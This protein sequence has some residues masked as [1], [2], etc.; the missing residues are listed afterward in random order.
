MS[1]L[2]VPSR[3]RIYSFFLIPL[4][5]F[6]N[7]STNDLSS[8]KNRNATALLLMQTLQSTRQ[9]FSVPADT[10]DTVV[11]APNHTGLG[12]QDKAKAINGVRGAGNY[13]GSGD[14][15]SLTATGQGSSI[16][17]EWSGR[18]ITNGAGIDF[19][20][21]ENPFY[22]NSSSAKAFLEPTLVE[23]S[24]DNIKYCGFNPTYSNIP[25]TSFSD[26]VVHWNKFAGI[27]PVL[28]NMETNPLSGNH[29]Y[30]ISKAGGDGFD[31]SDLVAD[32]NPDPTVGCTSNEVSMIQS[33][34]FV[35]LRLTAATAKN[36]PANPNSFGG[37][38]D[39]DGVLARYQIPR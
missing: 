28:Y 37:G 30:D 32:I 25:S 34:G 31:L 13:S 17:L 20:V 8:I 11:S 18:R 27:T 33:M 14:V 1:S 6:F 4:F 24:I 26:S 7:C 36:F 22:L 29:L 2:D 12:Y 39:I 16:V 15:Y 35:Y 9:T 10:A 38:A 5:F 21:F 3:I 19:I 23:V